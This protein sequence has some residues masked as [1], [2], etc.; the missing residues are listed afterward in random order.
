M[1]LD[2]LHNEFNTDNI[3]DLAM[4]LANMELQRMRKKKLK[5]ILYGDD[6]TKDRGIK[7]KKMAEQGLNEN[8]WLTGNK[9]KEEIAA[10]QA[11]YNEAMQKSLG[12]SEIFA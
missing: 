4:I 3:T 7:L 11:K 10:E 8:I 6:K 2:Q 12:L 1:K 9:T 5:D